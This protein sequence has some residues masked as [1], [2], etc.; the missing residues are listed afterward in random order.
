MQQTNDK[1]LQVAADIA[2][3]F[4]KNYKYPLPE[5]TDFFYTNIIANK[6]ITQIITAAASEKQLSKNA[7]FKNFVKQHKKE[8]YYRL[9]QYKGDVESKNELMEALRLAKSNPSEEARMALLK[10]LA[11]F[12]V[13]SQ[14][15]FAE[16]HLLYDQLSGVMDNVHCIVDAGCGVQ[17][18]FFPH[19]RFS[20]VEKYVALDK[21]KESV[22]LVE[23]FREVFPEQYK[24]LLPRVWNISEGWK[25]VCNE[26]GITVFDLALLLKLVPVVKRT[27]PALLDQLSR[28]P[29]KTIVISGVKES[30]V[31][32]HDIEHKERKGIDSFIRDAGRSK[33]GE[34]ELGNEFFIIVQ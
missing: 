16:N 13:S 6:E 2:A 4:V 9:R 31:R 14:E 19:S 27:N 33:T 23:T 21:D 29:A 24:W 26:Y 1:I 32:R 7:I 15:R 12:H 20:Q 5:A 8:L 10:D 17:P 18:L 11:A 22:R 34:F 25:A 3:S 28:I 30:M